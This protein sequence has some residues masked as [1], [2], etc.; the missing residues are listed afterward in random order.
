MSVTNELQQ[1]LLDTVQLMSTKAANSTNATLTVKCTVVDVID[2]GLGLYK[3]KYGDNTFEVYC[4]L[5]STFVKDDLVYVLIPD[6]DFSNE[7]L[8]VGS[9]APK[10]SMIIPDEESEIIVVNPDNLI[11][12]SD[13]IN[14]KTWENKILGTN[15]TVDHSLRDIVDFFKLKT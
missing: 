14:L 4:H 7:K 8:I 1:S 6:G 15:D 13:T 10:A 5:N 12:V 3:V 11:N 9:G 2:A